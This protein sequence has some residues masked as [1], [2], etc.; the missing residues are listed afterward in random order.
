VPL[1]WTRARASDSVRAMDLRPCG[2]SARQVERAARVLA[3]QPFL[4]SDEMQTGVAYSWLDAADPRVS[5]PLLFRKAAWAA[6]WG[7]I[8]DANG[9]LRA[10]YD[11]FVKEI[12]RRY[13]GGSLLDV[14]C[15]NG[16]FPVRAETLGIGRATGA[17][18]GWHDWLSIRFL[19]EVLGAS[20]HF[21]RAVYHPNGGAARCGGGTMWWSPRRSFAISPIRSSSWPI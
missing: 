14:A 11:D 6:E 13:P 17:D 2:L 9:R 18:L 1:I 19:N 10:M 7:R 12:A 20:V 16:Y 4:I 15:N 5:P 21:R 3:Y 8:D